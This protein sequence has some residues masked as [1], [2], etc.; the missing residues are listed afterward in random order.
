MIDRRGRQFLQHVVAVDSFVSQTP[1]PAVEEECVIRHG[2]VR[3]RDHVES[4]CAAVCDDTSGPKMK[5]QLPTQTARA[6]DRPGRGKMKHELRYRV[7]AASDACPSS[8][9]PAPRMICRGAQMPGTVPSPDWR[10]EAAGSRAA[11]MCIP[12]HQSSSLEK[13][14]SSPY[15]VK[16]VSPFL[17]LAVSLVAPAPFQISSSPVLRHI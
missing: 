5:R 14:S 2:A 17:P 3:V 16:Y 15:F 11:I 13:V 8:P 12:R 7:G 1:R 4:D 10:G 9:S 6:P